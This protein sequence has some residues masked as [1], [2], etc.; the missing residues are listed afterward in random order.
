MTN[1]DL[2]EGLV[3]HVQ[4]PLPGSDQ[5]YPNLASVPEKPP[6]PTPKDKRTDLVKKLEADSR[7]AVYQPDLSQAPQIPPEPAALPPGFLTANAPVKLPPEAPVIQRSTSA[8]PAPQ[9]KQSADSSAGTPSGG[10]PSSETSDRFGRVAVVLFQSGSSQ[11]DQAQVAELKPVVVT[12]HAQ[13]GVLRVVGYAAHRG[14]AAGEREKIADFNLSLDRANA[15]GRALIGLGV[16]PSELIL[17]AEGD[18]APL[19]SIAGVGGNAA[20]QR[21]D[22]YYER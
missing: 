14:G 19:L 21:A 7:S 10:T 2:R 9:P 22:I 18:R 12:L 3:R 15:V 5:P 6:Q 13:G 11:V 20:E 1:L 17:R 4:K 8:G 16:K